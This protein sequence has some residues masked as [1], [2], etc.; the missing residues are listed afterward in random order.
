MK[1]NGRKATKTPTF[2]LRAERALHRA[3][4]NVRVQNRAVG[5]P[6]IVWRDGKVAEKPA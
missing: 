4:H 1:T 5:L 3:A 6:V 2:V